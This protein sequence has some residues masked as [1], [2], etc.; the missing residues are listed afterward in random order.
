MGG[1]RGDHGR[2][3]AECD[4]RLP[5]L[6]GEGD[7]H[8]LHAR[9]RD[10]W[11]GARARPSCFRFHAILRIQP[12]TSGVRLLSLPPSEVDHGPAEAGH[13]VCERS[14]DRTISRSYVVS[15]FRRTVSVQE[16]ASGP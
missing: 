3:D 7:A 8:G 2:A 14:T 1:V 10:A 16:R 13:Y 9:D 11:H 4:L 12:R 6:P 15:A 5:D